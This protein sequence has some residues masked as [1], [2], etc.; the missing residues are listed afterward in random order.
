MLDLLFAEVFAYLDI[1][2]K[3][4]SAFFLLLLNASQKLGK[5]P[6]KRSLP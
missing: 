5:Y 3:L 4:D 6:L 1:S 2:E